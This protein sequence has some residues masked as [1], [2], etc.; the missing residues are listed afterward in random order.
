MRASQKDFVLAFISDVAFYK[1]T[2]QPMSAWND[3]NLSIFYNSRKQKSRENQ[4][5]SDALHLLPSREI[6]IPLSSMKV[7]TKSGTNLN[8]YAN[9]RQ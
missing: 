9:G 2:L 5:N 6:D 1:G 3:M 4:S 7:L 8:D